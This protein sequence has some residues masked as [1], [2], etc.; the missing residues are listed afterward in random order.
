MKN[1]HIIILILFITSCSGQMIKEEDKII[2]YNELPEEV[3]NQFSEIGE[4]INLFMDCKN[5][6]G[7]DCEIKS[8]NSLKTFTDPGLII[9]TNSKKYTLSFSITASRYF[10]IDDNYIYFPKI[11]GF[12]QRGD[13]PLKE[14]FDFS[15]QK[16]GVID[17]Q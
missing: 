9:D 11:K 2:S 10:V 4:T 3:K 6:M 7:F 17:L 8:G 1:F 15:E 5:T 12:S 16:Y 14:S 13:S